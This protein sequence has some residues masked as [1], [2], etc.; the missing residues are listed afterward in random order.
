L[1]IADFLYNSGVVRF[2][3]NGILI[4]S[5]P[6]EAGVNSDIATFTWYPSTAGT[7]TL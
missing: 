7:V 5:V 6:V 2:Y 1:P 3:A 4:G